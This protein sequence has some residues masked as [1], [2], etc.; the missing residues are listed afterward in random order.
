MAKQTKKA[1]LSRSYSFTVWQ[2]VFFVV[3]FGTLGTVAILSSSAA[4]KPKLTATIQISPNP[5]QS[6]HTTTLVTFTGC[7]YIPNGGENIVIGGTS[8]VGANTDSNGCLI[9]TQYNMAETTPGTVTVQVKEYSL[10][11]NKFTTVAQT[12]W[13]VN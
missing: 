2:L 9:N 13:V 4:P 12:L 8:D 3:A 10:K 5:I 6:S 1:M 11:T 7:G